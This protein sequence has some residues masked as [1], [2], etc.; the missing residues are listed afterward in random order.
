MISNNISFAKLKI[1]KVFLLLC[2]QGPLYSRNM[3]RR[4]FT[5]TMIYNDLS[6]IL[7]LQWFTNA[8]LFL[9]WFT[10]VIWLWYWFNGL[11]AQFYS[12]DNLSVLLSYRNGLQVPFYSHNMSE[13]FL[14]PGMIYRWYLLLQWITSAIILP[15]YFHECSFTKVLI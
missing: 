3:S 8:I 5:P 10:S 12:W 14:S 9:Q 11:S 15:W 13:G 6:T 4:M 1:T 2:L 7:L